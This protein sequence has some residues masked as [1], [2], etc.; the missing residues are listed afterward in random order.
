MYVGIDIGSITTKIAVMYRG[1]IVFTDYL[2][3][4]RKKLIHML[5][6]L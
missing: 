3:N 1:E 2:K 6:N 4:K 5:V